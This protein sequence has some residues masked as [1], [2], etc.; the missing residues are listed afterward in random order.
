MHDRQPVSVTIITLNEA[1]HIRAALES[2]RWADEIVVLD[3]GSIDDTVAICQEYP[4]RVYHV[5]WHGYVAQK[6]LATA[7]TSHD[8][9]LNIDADERVSAELAAEI[10]HALCAPAEI[11]GFYLPRR[12]FYLGAWIQHCGW[13]PDYKLRLFN[14]QAGRWVGQALHE[15]IAVDGPTAY[16]HGNID[17]YTY[18]NITDHLNKM[19][20]FTSLAAN[21]PQR[22]ISGTAILGRTLFAFFKKYVIKQGF[23]DGTRG[24][25]VSLFAAFGVSVKYA[26]IWERQHDQSQQERSRV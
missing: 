13:Y 24:L 15:K 18:E 11:V 6:N 21:E 23:R 12:T 4:T 2:V 8:W 17:H 19:N 3:S 9:V 10:Q 26:K 14:K 7:Q 20:N 1:R 5:A 16:L 25:I 22:P